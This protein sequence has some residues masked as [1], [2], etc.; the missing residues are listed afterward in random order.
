MQQ[1][2]KDKP[3]KEI[4]CNE[5][6]QL[7]SCDEHIKLVDVLNHSHYKKEHINGAIS[8][9]IRIVRKCAKKHL[10]KDDTIITYCA[11]FKCPASTDA[12]KILLSLG[13]KN[14]LDYKGGLAD[15][16]KANLPLE[17]S[18]YASK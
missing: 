9:P 10:N 11:N 2:H 15:Y 4:S 13:Y 3:V 8:L 6:I 18:L 5:L 17:G 12:A 7:R 16:K 14:V 1:L